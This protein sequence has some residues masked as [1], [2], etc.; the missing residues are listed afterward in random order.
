VP[1]KKGFGIFQIILYICHKRIATFFEVLMRISM[2]ANFN[3]VILE[4]G[5]LPIAPAVQKRLNLSP[6]DQV[7]INIKVLNRPVRRASQSRFDELWEKKDKRV[8]T[9]SE[10]AEL[11][12]LAD[13]EFDTAIARAKKIVQKKHPELFDEHGR[14][15]RRKALA[16]L[17]PL[18]SRRKAKSMA[19]KKRNS[20]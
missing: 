16:S 17:I 5:L 19:R 9:P 2:V 20:R 6:G 13:A 12:A 10:Q 15:R 11:V 4:N 3:A 1:E 8:L 14:L 7:R 18:P